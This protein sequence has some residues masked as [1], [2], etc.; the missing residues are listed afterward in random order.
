VKPY[1]QN[2]DPLASS[3]VG[4]Y[5]GGGKP[6]EVAFQFQQTAGGDL[7]IYA[8]ILMGNGDGTFTPTYDIFPFYVYGHP[9]Y[10]H[11]LDGDGIADMVEL[12]SGNSQVHVIKGGPAPA[13]QIALEEPIV[14]GS[15]GCGWVFPDVASSSSQTV[16]L[17]SSVGGVILPGS[18]TVP[19]GALSAQFCYSL[20]NNFNWHQVFDIN[21]KPF[22]R[23]RQPRCTKARAARRSR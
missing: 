19:A 10:A 7:G 6:D 22:L 15:Q 18:V 1:T 3:I 2:G 5:G 16:M 8:Q 11:D 9:L 20:A 14:T 13:L 21:V 17:S 12:D 23:S 4:V